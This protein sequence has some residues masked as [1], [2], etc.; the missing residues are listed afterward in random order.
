MNA[1]LPKPKL[2]FL[3]TPEFA[4]VCLETLVQRGFN[5]VGVVAQPDR[6]A[7]RGHHLS[8]PPVAQFAKES[9]LPLLQPENFKTP[10]AI[11]ALAQWQPDFL[12]V[13]AYG[14]ILPQAVLDIPKREALNVHASLLPR[15]RGAAP[16]QHAL[17]S[18]DDTTGISIMRM[19][20]RLDAGPV[21]KT[22]ELPIAFEDTTVTLTAKL[23][24][25]GADTLCDTLNELVQNPALQPSIQDESQ[26][27]LAPKIRR[28]MS[29]LHWGNSSRQ[30]Y[31]QIR[32][33]VP[34]PVAS[35]TFK[36]SPLK[37]HAAQI[38]QGSAGCEPGTILHLAKAGL[39]VATG[40]GQLLITQVQPE[41]KKIMHAFDWAN[42][43][44]VKVGEKFI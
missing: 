8:S 44:H 9:G 14:N 43:V 32:A 38:T 10:E 25:L 41:G 23:A 42:G 11:Q 35:T 12:I 39:T 6:P 26:A 22:R 33:L 7:G 3:G 28:E 29:A 17:L 36:G 18:G 1:L 15:Y 37:I 31:N 40:E 34:W 16:I 19:V 2:V 24:R 13:V 5:V 30:I 20:L 4:C 21:F 27:T